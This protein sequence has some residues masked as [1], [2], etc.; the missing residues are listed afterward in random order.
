[1]E[2]CIFCKIIS[3][4]IPCVKVYEDDEVFAFLDITQVTEGHTLVIPKKHVRNIFDMTDETA[5]T[6]FSRVPQIAKMLKDNLEAN[7]INIINNNEAIAYQSVFHS[8]VHLIPRYTEEDDF[9]INFTDHQ[10]DY[11]I[12]KLNKVAKKIIK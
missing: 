2:N 9:S 10:S 1:M 7:G 4:E 12:E 3:G 8:H 11:P 6:L 5:A